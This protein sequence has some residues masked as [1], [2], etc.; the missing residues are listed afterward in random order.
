LFK[1][2]QDSL[3]CCSY[4]TQDISGTYHCRGWTLQW[5]SFIQ[6]TFLLLSLFS[7]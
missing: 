3:C 2:V 4:I 7:L 6:H 1:Q 5:C